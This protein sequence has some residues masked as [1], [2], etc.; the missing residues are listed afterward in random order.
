MTP[1][2]ENRVGL[3]GSVWTDVLR[4]TPHIWTA[5]A[6]GAAGAAGKTP[7]GGPTCGPG[8]RGPPEDTTR[9]TTGCGFVKVL[10]RLRGNSCTEKTS[11][12]C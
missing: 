6:A 10:L 4:Q 1:A 5:A 7:R 11:E 3:S 8:P 12:F 2:D 9:T